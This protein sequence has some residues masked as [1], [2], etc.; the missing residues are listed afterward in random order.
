MNARDILGILCGI[1]IAVFAGGSMIAGLEA[2]DVGDP[3][4][5][6]LLTNGTEGTA[7]IPV[8]NRGITFD[9]PLP[10]SPETVPHY[11]VISVQEYSSGTGTALTIKDKIPSV[12]EAPEL[13]QKALGPYGGLPTDAV[14]EKTGQV[15]MKKYNLSTSVVEEEYPQYTQVTYRQYVH[16]SPVINSEISVALGRNGE[17][18]DYKKNWYVLEQEGYDPVISAEDA[19]E[20]LKKQDLLFRPQCCV[21]NDSIT[22]VQAGYYVTTH[23]PYAP[24]REALPDTCTPVWIFYAIK[25]GTG[26]DP[27]PLIVNATRG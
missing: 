15:T 27:F 20:K 1:V 24:D 25:P 22:R 16:G 9:V 26:T 8:Y 7:D 5:P 19:Q 4:G 18:L 14:L 12:S 13:A 21:S 11:R 17:L 6:V 10:P 23:D 2:F 3:R